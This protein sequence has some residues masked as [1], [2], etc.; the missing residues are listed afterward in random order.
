MKM[1]PLNVLC[2]L[3][4]AF[5]VCACAVKPVIPVAPQPIVETKQ[6]VDIDPSLVADCPGL[7]SLDVRNYSKVE[8][9]QVMSEWA[10]QYSGCA[11]NHH[12]L[13]G[14]AIKAFNLTPASAPVAASAPVT[15]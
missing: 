12:N 11:R 3:V 9:L 5:A 15:K 1:R 4:I 14:L 8:A 7:Q 10:N 6:T 13:A 2:L